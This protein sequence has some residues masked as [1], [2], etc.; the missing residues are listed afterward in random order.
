MVMLGASLDILGFDAAEMELALE[1]LFGRKG[2]EVM[3]L[4]RDAI[5]AG[6]GAVIS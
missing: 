6:A 1:T 2:E 5:L 4:N 3:Q